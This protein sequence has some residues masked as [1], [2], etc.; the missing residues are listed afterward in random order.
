MLGSRAGTRD[1][2][3]GWRKL[4]VLVGMSGGVDSSVAACLL[5]QQGH[6][7]TGVTLKLWGGDSDS[8]C[9]TLADA[10]DARRVADRM[11]IPHMV[12]SFSDVFES[13][14]VSPYVQ[15]H[16]KGITPNPCV[17]CNRRI[18]WGALLE[19]AKRLGFDAVATGH[20]ARLRVGSST[21]KDLGRSSLTSGRVAPVRLYRGVDQGKDQSYVLSMVPAHELSRSLLPIGELTKAEVRQKAKEL[22]LRVA[23]KPDSQEVC[24]ISRS[25][26][27][28]GFLSSRAELHKARMRE[29]S[30]GRIIGELEALELVTV[31]Q[32]RGLGAFL[33]GEAPVRRYAVSVDPEAREVLVGTEEELMCEDME[34]TNLNWFR[35]P[36]PHERFLAQAS[37]HGRP[38][39]VS[40][41]ELSADSAL[42]ALREPR[43]RVAPGQVVAFYDIEDPSHVVGA[44]KVSAQKTLEST[45]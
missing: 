24:F 38:F 13:E 40:L 17:E 20:H 31:G 27:R 30:T 25:Q 39:E 4:R 10:D 43:R 33:P 42:I 5:M 41:Q 3:G 23:S 36:L 1:D 6:E 32:R 15:D 12:W 8:G 16:L 34:V 45:R 14:V 2:G 28:A 19:R 37:A 9:C 29:A 35:D 21:P 26:G 44:G 11:G 18:K 7:V 22:G